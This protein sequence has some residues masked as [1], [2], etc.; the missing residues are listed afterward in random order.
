M[1]GILQAYT[2]ALSYVQLYGPTL[3]APSIRMAA[4]YAS[5]YVSQQKQK[6]FILLMI[7]DGVITGF[8]FFF[9]LKN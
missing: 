8:I 9:F 5:Q 3:F 2:Q 4:Q 1:Q 7:T 6:Y